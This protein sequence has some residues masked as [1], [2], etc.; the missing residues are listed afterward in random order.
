MSL[1][2]YHLP[3]PRDLCAQPGCDAA[4]A[5]A[6]RH[7]RMCEAHTHPAHRRIAAA[8]ALMTPSVPRS[9]A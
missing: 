2:A 8:A 1:P 3:E 4:A 7:G 9:A 5:W 6:T